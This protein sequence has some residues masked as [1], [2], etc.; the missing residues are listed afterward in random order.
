MI[1]QFMSDYAAPVVAAATLG[2]VG[3]F[4][5]VAVDVDPDEQTF[6]E[7]FPQLE[8]DNETY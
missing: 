3:T 2:V 6:R 1:Q 7:L 5:L 4:T 8:N